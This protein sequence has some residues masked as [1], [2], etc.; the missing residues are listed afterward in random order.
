MPGSGIV[1]PD[2]A[3]AARRRRHPMSGDDDG[4]ATVRAPRRDLVVYIGLGSLFFELAAA[5]WL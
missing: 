3:R 1:G 4:V 5:D 2:T